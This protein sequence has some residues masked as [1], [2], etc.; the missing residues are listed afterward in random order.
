MLAFGLARRWPQ[1][2]SNAVTPGWVPTRM[3]GAGAPDDLELGAR[4]QAWLAAG[5][6]PGTAVTGQYFY[7]QRSEPV[8]DLVRSADDQDALFDYCAEL[9]GRRL[10]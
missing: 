6:D 1:V 9:T 3:G 4:T 5:D 7:H 10:T 8:P 2:R